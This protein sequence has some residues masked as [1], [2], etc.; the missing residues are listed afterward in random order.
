MFKNKKGF[1]L[2]EL[3]VVIAIIGIL[4]AVVLASL[5]TA[6]QKG[7]DAAAKESISSVRASAEIFYNGSVGNNSYGTAGAG[8]GVCADPDVAKLLTA[9]GVQTGT[10][11]ACT[12]GTAGAG[13]TAQIVLNDASTF[14]VDSNG[15]A[16]KPAGTVTAGVKCQ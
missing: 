8:A 7:K 3:L 16:G 15:F 14:C 11:A 4:S 6:R 12:T 9:A 1:T 13:Y 5:N 10:T 2:I